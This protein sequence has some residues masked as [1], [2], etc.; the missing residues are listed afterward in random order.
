MHL[1]KNWA[2]I[3]NKFNLDTLLVFTTMVFSFVLATTT[4]FI[5]YV[6]SVN[7]TWNNRSQNLKICYDCYESSVIV[8][9]YFSNL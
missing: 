4:S 5:Y 2:T 9:L 7:C 3:G 8:T 1:F 6:G